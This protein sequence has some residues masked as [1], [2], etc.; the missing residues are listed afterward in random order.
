[1]PL[2]TPDPVV[3]EPGAAGAP[4]PEGPQALAG[5]FRA[6]RG[7]ILLTYGLFN[8]ENL[9]QLAQP[10]VLGLAINDLLRC[11]GR[12]LLLLCAQHLSMLVL[13]VSR[14]AYDTR[15]FSGIYADLATRFVLEQKGRGVEVSR[16]TAR[17]ALSRQVVEFFE[18]DIPFVFQSLYAVVGA[19][20][21]LAL[22]DRILVFCCL[23]FLALAYAVS[24][25]YGRTTL[26]LSGR[27]HD[28]MEREVD[29]LDRGRPAEVHGHYRLLGSWRVKLSDAEATTFG[30][31]EL[32]GF[33]LIVATLTRTC[34]I[35][36]AEVGSISAVL[37][38]VLMFSQNVI[39]LPTLVAQLSRLRD[40]SRRVGLASTPSR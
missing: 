21:M 33:T 39:N 28:Q 24:R 11:S 34:G 30:V 2:P 17:S 29:V 6:Y 16:L 32:I 3:I 31:M 35:S 1:M 12:G 7:R 37:G 14:R 20:I 26:A 27:L 40:V 23:L 8:T 25:A 38:Y 13:S 15:A 19:L 18:H 9:L 5:L 4:S 36:G 10:F 22:Y